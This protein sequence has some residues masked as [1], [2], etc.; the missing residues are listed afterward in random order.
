MQLRR[1]QLFILIGPS[2]TG[3]TTVLKQLKLLYGRRGLD[4]ERQTF[5]RIVH[6]NVMK[7]MQTLVNGMEAAHIPL[8][9]HEN[10]QHLETV[11]R[12][13]SLLK[14]YSITSIGFTNPA[15]PRKITDAKA[16]TDLF[17]E[18]VPAIGALWADAGIQKTYRTCSQLNI[19]D[20][21]A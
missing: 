5:R 16:E 8:E 18:M 12:L 17:E 21:A 11:L 6:L 13:E 3:K 7:A 20:S 9:K 15:I 2:E 19:Q 14:R 4:S 10:E 1:K